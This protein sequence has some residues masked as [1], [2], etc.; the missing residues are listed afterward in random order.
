MQQTFIAPCPCFPGFYH[1]ALFDPDVEF[2]A[3]NNT[4]KELAGRE[5]KKKKRAGR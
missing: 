4:L 1:T 2:Y 3:V 5:K